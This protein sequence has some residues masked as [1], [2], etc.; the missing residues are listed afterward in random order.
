MCLSMRMAMRCA[1]VHIGS[2]ASAGAGF[3]P[4]HVLYCIA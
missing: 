3:N 2:L 1:A 4:E